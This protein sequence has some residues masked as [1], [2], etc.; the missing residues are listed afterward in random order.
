MKTE[1]NN[2]FGDRMNSLVNDE[3]DKNTKFQIVMSVSCKNELKS[4]ARKNRRSLQSHA[5]YLLELVMKHP[6]FLKSV[7]IQV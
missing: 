4:D 6:E 2:I 3:K 7:E 1:E 5:G